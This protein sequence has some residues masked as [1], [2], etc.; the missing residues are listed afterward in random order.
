MAA[1]RNTQA[2]LLLVFPRSTRYSDIPVFVDVKIVDVSSL[3][4]ACFSFQILKL[5]G[6]MRDSLDRRRQV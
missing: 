3:V 6:I 4:N 5:L 1:A 2:L